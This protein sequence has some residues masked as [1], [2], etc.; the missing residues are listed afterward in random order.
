MK[1]PITDPSGDNRIGDE[2][3]A[4]ARATVDDRDQRV[5]EMDSVD[6]QFDEDVVAHERGPCGTRLSCR[7]RTMGIERV[8]ERACSGV[9]GGV[10]LI[11]CRVAVTERDDDSPFSYVREQIDTT[12]QLRRDCHVPDRTSIEE[13][14]EEVVVRSAQVAGVVRARPARRQ[15][16]SFEVGRKDPSSAGELTRP[17]DRLERVAQP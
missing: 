15:E 9:E 5:V 16:R 3:H 12:G 1:G 6:D 13:A 2:N 4:L 14:V 17:G 7:Q 8:G 11:K 10:G